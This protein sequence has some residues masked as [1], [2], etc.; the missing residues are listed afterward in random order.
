MYEKAEKKLKKLKK[1]LKIRIK[2]IIRSVISR[3]LWNDERVEALN[4]AV[5]EVVKREISPY[6]LA[7]KIVNDYKL[8]L[9]ENEK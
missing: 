2:D 7:D 6:D 9:T 4:S 5:E 3:E 8:Y 1:E